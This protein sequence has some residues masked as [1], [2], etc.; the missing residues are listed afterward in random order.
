MT[1]R[2]AAT[3]RWR[4]EHPE[5]VR[6]YHNK[7]QRSESYRQRRLKRNRLRTTFLRWLKDQPCADCREEFPHYCMDFDHARGEK[8]MNVTTMDT[9]SWER[10]QAELQKCDVVCAICHRKRTYRRQQA[11]QL[12]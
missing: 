9:L 1:A 10:I 8:F 7:Y 4:E 12:A 2:Q 3:Q 11:L 6:A 5:Q